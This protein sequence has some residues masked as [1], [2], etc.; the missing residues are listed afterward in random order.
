MMPQLKEQK[1]ISK[2][3]DQVEWKNPGISA[4]HKNV[5]GRGVGVFFVLVDPFA[6]RIGIRKRA[7]PEWSPHVPE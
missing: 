2:T 7:S 3:I 5:C 4:A 6:R 1:N